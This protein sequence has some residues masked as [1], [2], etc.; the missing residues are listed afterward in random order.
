MNISNF[1]V[2]T[3]GIDPGSDHLRITNDKE[4][5]F[6]EPSTI[7]ISIKNGKV[8]G[9]GNSTIY[10]DSE[11]I[12]QPI[13]HVNDDFVGFEQLLRNAL[14]KGL[15]PK[16]KLFYPSTHMYLSLPITATPVDQRAYKDSAEH[17]GASKV[18]MIYQPY[19]AALGIGILSEKKD[20]ILVD[21]SA[22]KV[23]ISVIANQEVISTGMVHFGTWKIKKVLF[24]FISRNFNLQLTDIELNN[25][26][27]SL[28]H[29][30]SQL[31]PHTID[32]QEVFNHLSA[33]CTF[34]EDELM[35]TIEKVDE[36]PSIDKI[37]DNGIYFT[38]GGSY[39]E[40][41]IKR[42]ATGTK[43]NYYT[44]QTPLLDTIQ[45][46]MKVIRNPKEFDRY[47]MH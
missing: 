17:A 45:G 30:P 21:F 47:L 5:I 32:S 40:W 18:Y 39:I 19:V 16:S 33:C 44:S 15:Q 41:I 14:R 1:L 2:K 35:E 42:L 9:F 24:N 10:Q 3:V 20:F 38:G 13:Y 31:K 22:S 23:E 12:I 11:E 36:H 26:L 46:L 7:S 34:I 25:M 37:L 4:I 28:P 27:L 29:T 6:N 43:L 8:S